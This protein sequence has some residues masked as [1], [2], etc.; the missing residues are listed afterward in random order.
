MFP[1]IGG[2]RLERG[3]HQLRGNIVRSKEEESHTDGWFALPAAATSAADLLEMRLRLRQ[4]LESQSSRHQ[5]SPEP[6][7]AGLISK[8]VH[9]CSP[10]TRVRPCY[11]SAGRC[12]GFCQSCPFLNLDHPVHSAESREIDQAFNSCSILQGLLLWLFQKGLKV[13]LLFLK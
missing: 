1:S 8:V 12:E 2:S 13:G 3:R 6:T 11:S 7:T 4:A 9:P 10:P 5:L